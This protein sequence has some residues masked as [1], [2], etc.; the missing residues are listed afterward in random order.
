MPAERP[1]LPRHLVEVIV[2]EDGDDAAWVGPIPVVVADRDEL[3]EAVHLHR[4]VTYQSDDRPR[5]DAARRAAFLARPAA[6][7]PEAT[8]ASGR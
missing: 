4:A 7:V 2:M 5:C 3:V 6:N 8:V 1:Q